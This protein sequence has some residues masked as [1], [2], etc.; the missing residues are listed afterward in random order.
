MAGNNSVDESRD[1]AVFQFA[2]GLVLLVLR[3]RNAGSNHSKL[4][5]N[6]PCW[7]ENV[8]RTRR[9]LVRLFLK[10]NQVQ[11]VETTDGAVHVDDEHA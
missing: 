9:K 5:H 7:L 6:N 2:G 8:P 11:H 3:R 4:F 1:W 10:D